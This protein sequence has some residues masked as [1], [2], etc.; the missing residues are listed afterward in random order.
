VTAENP[1]SS[2]TAREVDAPGK[3]AARRLSGRRS[4][5]ASP[6]RVLAL[7]DGVFAIVLTLLVLEIG[8]PE[9]LATESLRS[10][11]LELRPTLV[12]WV[13]S[14]LITGMYWVGHRDLFNRVQSVNRDLVWLNLL[15]LLAVSLIPSPHRCSV[16]TQRN[17]SPCI[18][19]G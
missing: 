6:D 8:V 1:A 7:S 18:C 5:Q 14:F 9:N 4:R 10:S 19:T 12:A 13:I 2:G 3:G 11:L 15:F 16:S 17:R